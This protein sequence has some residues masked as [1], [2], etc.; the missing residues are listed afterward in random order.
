MREL[1]GVVSFGRTDCFDFLALLG[2]LFVWKL[3]PGRLYLWVRR[4]G[5]T[6]PAARSGGAVR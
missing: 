1:S 5:S 3:E 6:A 4:G 2:D